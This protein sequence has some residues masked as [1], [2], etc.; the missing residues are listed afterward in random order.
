VAEGSEE[1]GCWR[2]DSWVVVGAL[3]HMSSSQYEFVEN[4]ERVDENQRYCECRI[5]IVYVESFMSMK[6]TP[7]QSAD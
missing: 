6:R 1:V 5:S 2:E 4:D 3:S 7:H